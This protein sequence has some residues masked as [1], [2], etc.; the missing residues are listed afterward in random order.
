MSETK[1]IS[2]MASKISGDLFEYLKWQRKIVEDHS[3]ECV[4]PEEHGKKKDHPSDCVFYYRDPYDNEMKYIN[5]DLKSFKKNSINK[6]QIHSALESL[7]YATNCAGYNPNWHNLYKPEDSHSV[8]GMLF[9]YNHCNSYNGDF[10]E[11]IR[12]ASDEHVNH[13]D[14]GNKIFVCSPEKIVELYSMVNDIQV[15]IGKGSLP[16]VEHYCFFHP[17]EVLNKNHFDSVYGEPATIETLASPWI[18]VKHA[19]AAKCDAGFVIYYMKEG[20]EVDEFVYLLDALSYYQVLNEKG[21]VRIKLIKKNEFS[22]LNLY[23]AID[24]YFGDLGYSSERIEE[25][26]EKLVCGTIAKSQPQFSAVEIG[27]VK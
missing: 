20:S 21:S 26:K 4:T 19:K 18:I 25:I 7:S 24:Q 22:A 13:L 14:S 6:K 16:D 2:E 11:L 8:Y 3:W 27:I 12:T 1:M 23:S 17:S 9:V 15:M 5:T 10:D